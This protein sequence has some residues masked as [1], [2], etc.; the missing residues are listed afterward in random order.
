MDDWSACWMYSPRN[1]RGLHTSWFDGEEEV[2]I[3]VYLVEM[4]NW[5]IEMKKKSNREVFWIC[6][7]PDCALWR[8]VTAG[9]CSYVMTDFKITGSKVEAAKVFSGVS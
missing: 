8:N 1:R 2:C 5:T 7:G 4:I 3:R 6:F 9:R